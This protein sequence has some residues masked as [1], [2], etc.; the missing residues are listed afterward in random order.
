MVK[1]P[2]E[3]VEVAVME[4]ALKRPE[5]YRPVVVAFV[6][7]GVKPGKFWGVVGG[8]VVVACKAVKF[9]RVVEPTTRR[10]PLLLKVEVAVPPK[11]AAVK[12]ARVVEGALVEGALTM[13]RLVMVEVAVLTRILPV[14]WLA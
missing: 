11:R 4:L 6:V 12:T 1:P 14:S 10:S 5:T 3:K 9:W 7:V 8:L 13:V 2:V